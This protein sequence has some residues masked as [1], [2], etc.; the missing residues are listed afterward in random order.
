[1]YGLSITVIKKVLKIAQKT[2]YA[3]E[4]FSNFIQQFQ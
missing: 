4:F 1:M 3:L 2:T